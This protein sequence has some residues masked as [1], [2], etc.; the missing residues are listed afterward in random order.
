MGRLVSTARRRQA[1]RAGGRR[2]RRGRAT[3]SAGPTTRTGRTSPPPRSRTAC[4]CSRTCTGLDWPSTS[5][6]KVVETASPYLYGYA[7]WYMRLRRADRGWRRRPARDPA[8]LRPPLVQRQPVRGPLDQR[9]LRRTQAAALAMAELGKEQ[10]QPEAIEA[11]DPGRLKL[12]D[13][14]DPDLQAERVRGPGALR[15]QHLVGGA[16]RHHG[17]D[18]ARAPHGGDQGGRRRPGRLPRPRRTRRSWLASSTGEELLDLL[19]EVG[20]RRRRPA[21]SSV[22]WSSASETTGF[23]RPGR[24]ARALRGP[25]RSRAKAGRH[26]PPSGWRWRTGGSAPRRA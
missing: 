5:T 26:P 9:G 20:G 14:S 4:P 18:R 1:D 19:E 10:A 2:R 21:S 3:C 15:L 12:N 11:G 16:R 23:G 13:W 22:T 25:A 7:G 6:L 24:G 17:R 8:R